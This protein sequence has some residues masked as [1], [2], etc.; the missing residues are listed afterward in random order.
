MNR[1][2]AILALISASGLAFAQTGGAAPQTPPQGQA[3][4]QPATGATAGQAPAGQAATPAPAPVGKRQPQAKTQEE[5][6]A[7]QDAAAKPDPA[8]MEQ[9]A[10]AFAKQFPESELRAP[11]YQT[12]M[13]QYQN[14]NNAEKVISSGRKSI[15]LDPDNAVALVT[16]ASTI[17]VK[18][19]ETDIDKEERL[20]EVKKDAQRAIELM[21]SGKGVP[22][23]YTPDQ[24]GQY[25]STILAMAYGALGQAEFVNNN[26]AAA[27]QALR[28]STS[29][30]NI[31]ADPITWFQLSLSLDRQ[32]KY[33]DA[34][35]AAEKCIQVAQGHP[36]AKY[37]EQERDHAK[38]AAANPPANK[39]AST[40]GPQTITP[41]P[42]TK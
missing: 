1:T 8:T 23:N 20:A 10:D 27:E 40:S 5:F 33:A 28:K 4:T 19:R 13:L 36:V 30:T 18:T 14:A 12:V 42:T 26:Y 16:V 29:F 2:I 25:K 17:A 34:Q 41:G 38:Q 35:Q 7:Y 31:Q 21:D 37:C 15:E 39:P 9:S 6:K 24:A 22:A 32:Q 11:L 3:Q